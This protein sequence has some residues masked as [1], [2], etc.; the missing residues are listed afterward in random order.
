M[1]QPGKEEYDSLGTSP[2][3]SALASARLT[4][5]DEFAEDAREARRRARDVDV[6]LD[7]IVKTY[8]LKKRWKC[9]RTMTGHL[10]YVLSLDAN[11]RHVCSGSVD[12]VIKAW[13]VNTFQCVYDL[14]GHSM[15]IRSIACAPDMCFSGSA[16]RKVKAWDLRSMKCVT[17]MAEHTLGIWAII[18]GE[19]GDHR[20]YSGA[21]DKCVKVWDMRMLKK[22]VFTLQGHTHGIYALT[23]AE[24]YDVKHGPVKYL[25]SGSSDASIRFWRTQSPK[26][27]CNR[28]LKGNF[29]H[30][31]SLAS[32]GNL[33]FAGFADNTIKVWDTG[34]WKQIKNLRNHSGSILSLKIIHLPEPIKDRDVSLRMTDGSENVGAF[35]VV[36]N[37]TRAQTAQQFRDVGYL[38]SGSGDSSFKVWNMSSWKCKQTCMG[39]SSDINSM[40]YVAGTDHPTT[41][42]TASDDCNLKAWQLA[43][44]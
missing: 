37:N 23:L 6:N 19:P 39:H 38:F 12:N 11:Q 42:F 14:V 28:T 31:Y 25:V 44:M 32:E 24:T 2:I 29:D 4:D 8:Q 34:S 40:A 15:T 26:F 5:D 33:V 41:I 17:T 9:V 43:D 20:L 3:D 35:K 16:D 1:I 30:C 10:G 18:T 36:N 13:D 27:E 22:S 21:G 7:E